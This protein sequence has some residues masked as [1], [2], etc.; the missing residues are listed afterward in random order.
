VLRPW[1]II[2][3]SDDWDLMFTKKSMKAGN[4]VDELIVSSTL[5]AYIQKYR[6]DQCFSAQL[7]I[8]SNYYFQVNI[9]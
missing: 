9:F 6:E 2:E 1:Y 7:Y 4:A 8:K 5:L 3:L